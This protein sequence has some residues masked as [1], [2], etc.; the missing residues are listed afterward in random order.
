MYN[1]QFSLLS[2]HQKQILKLDNAASFLT[3]H[4]IQ[5]DNDEL[6]LLIAL[7]EDLSDQERLNLT[8]DLEKT[9]LVREKQKS[10]LRDVQQLLIK[11][12]A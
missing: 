8:I 10:T 5:L 11:L 9:R 6:K 2:P 1:S 7:T 12:S 3:G 4:I